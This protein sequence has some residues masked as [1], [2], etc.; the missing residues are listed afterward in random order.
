MQPLRL[1]IE[2]QDVL[3][4]IQLS[5]SARHIQSLLFPV[6]RISHQRDQRT[7]TA[8]QPHRRASLYMH[9]NASAALILFSFAQRG[10][11]LNRNGNFIK[12]S[13]GSQSAGDIFSA[14]TGSSLGAEPDR[15]FS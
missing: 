11:Y 2:K 9:K 7:G 13:F 5:A 14:V 12:N 15:V 4:L 3:I 6:R 1:V 10:I 8:F